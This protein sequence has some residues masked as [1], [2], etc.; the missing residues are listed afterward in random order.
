VE[1]P[2]RIVV[3]PSSLWRGRPYPL[4]ATWEGAGVNFALFSKHAERVELCLF[5][6][7]GRREVERVELLERTNFVWHCYLPDARPG[8]LYG[9]RVHG[10][11]DTEH[12]HRF[13]PTNFVLDRY[14]KLIRGKIG[15][16]LGR[17]QVVDTAFSW[18]ED[19]PPRTPWQDTLIYELHVKGFTQRH[20]E[21]PEQFRGT[22]A[23][24]ATAPAIEHL[25]KLGVTAVELLPVHAFVDER[26]VVQHGLRNYWG[27]NSIGFFA[28]ELR[29][30]ATGTLGEFKSMVKT[31]HSVGIEVILDVVYNHTGEGDH[32]GP[33]LSFRG[34]DN[35]I[36]Y[37]LDPAN[38][39]RYLNFTGTGNSLNSAHRVVLAL[40]MDSLRYW[41]EEMHVDGFRF[42]LAAT[43]A[44]NTAHA[45]DR[46]GAF[47]SAI[48]Q[49]PVLS[50]VKLIAEP[51]DVAEGGYQLGNFPPGW[52]EW[53]DK[54]RDSVRSYWKGEGVIGEVAS[55]LSGSSDIFQPAGRGPAASINFVA[56]HDGFTLEDL[57]S[58]N[59]KHNEANGEANGDGS[60]NNRSW[61]CGTEGPTDNP[62]ILS[63]REKQKRNL[64]ATLLFS[65]GVPMLVAGDELGRTQRGNN[66]AY[67]HDSELSWIDW[68]NADRALLAFVVK[69]IGLRNR[70]PLFRR[71]TYFRGREVREAQMKD[72]SWLNPDASEM[73]DEDW[74]RSSVRSL[75][76]LISGRG[77]SERDELG[78]PVEDD[79]VLVLLNA[80]DDSVAF[81][82]PG[83][84]G[85]HWDALIDTGHPA[86]EGKRYGRGTTY[87]LAARGL[88][89]LV[90]P[91]RRDP[92][93]TDG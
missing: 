36:Y 2:A 82:L 63:L 21:V 51:W 56:A 4:G 59:A 5:D 41:V 52:A 88:A 80:H 13:E 26:H 86:F 49:D 48:R 8:L 75:G 15:A 42:D 7:K 66:N 91:N 6:P 89:L 53:N 30:S 25:K 40:V 93:R 71:R 81:T 3:A 84:E 76:V 19:R 54:Y 9:Y 47:L 18:A 37:R 33:T 90:K 23:G 74:A 35:A 45:F 43:L 31:L 73:S 79:D 55:R 34:I 83:A 67:C 85:E 12:G 27:Y 87:P 64:L 50:Q 39:R 44:R 10:P 38:P 14:A 70:H 69:L 46:N 92:A 72:I 62:A 28:P 61:N 24:L 68:E 29:Y 22:Y 11:N 78:R 77:L 16:G 60:D 58:Y 32:A 17:C 57:V 1:A 20:P 65:Q